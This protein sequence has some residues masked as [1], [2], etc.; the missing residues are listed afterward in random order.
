MIVKAVKNG[1]E[2]EGVECSSYKLKRLPDEGGIV[3]FLLRDQ[4]LNEAN[5]LSVW[6]KVITMPKDCDTVY[7]MNNHGDTTD[8]VR[9]PAKVKTEFKT[10]ANGG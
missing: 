6:T 8:T 5:E 3:I 2:E 7:I 10:G 9:W 1:V 4:G